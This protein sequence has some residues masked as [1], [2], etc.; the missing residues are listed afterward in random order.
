MKVTVPPSFQFPKS[1]N[2]NHSTP[3]GPYRHGC[4]P[5]A[6]PHEASIPCVTS[7]GTTGFFLCHPTDS[8]QIRFISVVFNSLLASFPNLFSGH[9]HGLTTA[10]ESNNKLPTAYLVFMCMLL[11]LGT[12]SSTALLATAA[13]EPGTSASANNRLI[14]LM[15]HVEQSLHFGSLDGKSVVIPPGVYLIEPLTQ[16][17]PHLAFWHEHGTITLQATRTTHDQRVETPEAYLFREDKHEDIHHVVVFI[18]DGTALE[19]IGSVS[20]IQTRGK[21]RITR[22]YKVD[23]E[24][25]VVQFGDGQQGRRLPT[26]QSNI[27]AQYRKGPGNQGSEIRIPQLQS[28]LEARE[29]MLAISKNFLNNLNG[30]FQFE[31]RTDRPGADYA[32]H[33]EPSPE[34][35]RTR[36]AGDVNC[37]AFTFVKPNSGFPQGQCFLKRSEPQPIVN[38]CCVSGTRKSSQEKILRNIGR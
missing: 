34:S 28:V 2:P 30:Q 13:E 24:T 6:S 21:F 15:V 3:W 29:R 17:E 23:Q 25:G 12:I 16:G 36:C 11:N 38:S 33:L 22:R 31:E 7:L 20:G 14:P 1:G 19:T 4:D 37:Q 27:S 35:C 8:P 18:P 5:P 9:R 10:L 32:R 26:G